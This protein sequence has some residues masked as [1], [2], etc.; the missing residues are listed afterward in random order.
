[1]QV[2]DNAFGAELARQMRD[3]VA[4]LAHEARMH[5]N[6]THLVK[7]GETEFLCEF[8]KFHSC[9]G[10]G[11]GGSE[12]A[13]WAGFPRKPPGPFPGKKIRAPARE[14]GVRGGVRAGFS[15]CPREAGPHAAGL[16]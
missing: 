7:A 16:R 6:A 15:T 14:G 11:E 1:M 9:A 10:A 5:R 12:G 2:V 4:G 13:R 3:E 8:V